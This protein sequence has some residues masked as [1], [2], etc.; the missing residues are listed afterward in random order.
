MFRPPIITIKYFTTISKV[1]KIT[2]RK[3]NPTM[4]SKQ[5]INLYSTQ[6][7][8]YAQ[9]THLTTAFNEHYMYEINTVEMKENKEKKQ[10]SVVVLKKYGKDF[11]DIIADTIT[12]MES[13]KQFQVSDLEGDVSDIVSHING[14]IDACLDNDFCIET[15]SIQRQHLN[16]QVNPACFSIYNGPDNCEVSFKWLHNGKSEGRKVS[17]KLNN[18]D[19]YFV[20]MEESNGY[21]IGEFSGK[22]EKKEKL[23]LSDTKTYTQRGIEIKGVNGAELRVAIHKETRQVY[24]KNEKNWNEEGN[25]KFQELFPNGLSVS[26][27]KK[28]EPKQAIPVETQVEVEAEA[29]SQSIQEPT[30]TQPIVEEEKDEEEEINLDDLVDDLVDDL[31]EL[32]ID[33]DDET[34]QSQHIEISDTEENLFDE[35][36]EQE[37]E[38]EQEHQSE[39]TED[40]EEEINE[41]LSQYGGSELNEDPY[42][43][44]SDVETSDVQTSRTNNSTTFKLQV[45][46][47]VNIRLL[48]TIIP[49]SITLCDESGNIEHERTVYLLLEEGITELSIGKDHRVGN[50]VYGFPSKYPVYCV[51]SM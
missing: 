38:Q 48:E 45:D 7:I 14:Q 2:N 30:E 11:V 21:T 16:Y 33:D 9:L 25:A 35:E 6:S 42:D 43:E 13:E 12:T 34:S 5:Q 4:Q 41:Q 27:R 32:D 46:N 39:L 15:L 10:A 49:K 24:K 44:P 50:R 36:Q 29:E 31:G 22:A 20:V 19:A 51:L 3:L 23:R 1:Y 40:D 26:K 37:Q 18:G 28:T 8:P 47:V 17:I